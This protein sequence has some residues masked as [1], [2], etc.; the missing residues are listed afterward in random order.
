MSGWPGRSRRPGSP[1]FG[2]SIFT[3]SA[4]SHASASVQDGPASNWV[5]STIL[6]PERNLNSAVA[7]LGAIACAVLSFINGL[8]TWADWLLE[9]ACHIG[10]GWARVPAIFLP[11]HCPRR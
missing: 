11:Q 2:F 3:T 9:A 10:A 6:T 4:P 8:L 7:L 5:K 1:I